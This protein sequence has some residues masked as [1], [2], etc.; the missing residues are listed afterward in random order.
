MCK[1]PQ[2]RGG[3]CHG[4]NGFPGPVKVTPALGLQHATPG[5]PPEGGGGS[6]CDPA[7]PVLSR[8][9]SL[10]LASNYPLGFGFQIFARNLWQNQEPIRTNRNCVVVLPAPPPRGS[11]RT[12]ARGLLFLVKRTGG[13]AGPREKWT[14][15]IPA[16]RRASW[17]DPHSTPVPARSC[18]V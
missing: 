12:R 8:D 1:T 4:R 16:E 5:R 2:A 10:F 3:C 18:G 15:H 6:H 14:K 11:V 17:S 13:K 9:N 7:A